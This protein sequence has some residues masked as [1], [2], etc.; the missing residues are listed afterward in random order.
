MPTKGDK[1]CI[2]GRTYEFVPAIEISNIPA[3]QRIPGYLAD[4]GA[5]ST[6]EYTGEGTVEDS[7]AALSASVEEIR[8]TIVG[9]Y[10]YVGV[11]RSLK[12]TIPKNY[13]NY[14]IDFGFPVRQFYFDTPAA[15]TVRLNSP[16]ADPIDVDSASSP[17]ALNDLPNKLA[18]TSIYVTNAN[19]VDIIPYIF[20]MG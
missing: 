16:T 3:G 5:V 18:F 1:V 14:K 13:S 11:Y 17:L 15:L 10:D 8:K 12:E 20:V 4:T 2:K 6:G 19:P 9:F 7:L